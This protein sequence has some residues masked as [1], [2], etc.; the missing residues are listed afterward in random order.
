[1]G[2]GA[3]NTSTTG[4]R[5][6]GLGRFALYA[7][8]TGRSNSAVGFS[9]LVSNT[10]GSYNSAIG[11]TALLENTTGYKNSAIGYAALRNNTTGHHNVAFGYFAGSNQDTGHDNIYLVNTGVAGESGQIKIGTAGTHTKTTIA[12]I[13]GTAVPGGITVL[14]DSNG[15]LG[16]TVSSARFK[17]D[18]RDMGDSSDVLMKLRPVTF[19]YR[20]DVVGKEDAKTPQ[21]GLIAEEVEEVAPELVAPDLDGKPYSVKYQEL[22][23]LLLNE[24]QKEERVIEKEEQLIAA[25]SAQLEADEGASGATCQEWR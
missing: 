24:L 17:Q 6:T 7:D 23:A 14:V 22:P 18:V 16:T 21:Y 20:E 25:L 11:H 12:G 15:V 1:M 2:E 3:G 13:R 4:I 19:R 10:T 5:D 8:T 9:A